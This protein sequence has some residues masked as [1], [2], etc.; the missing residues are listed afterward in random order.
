MD[1]ARCQRAKDGPSGN[2]RRKRGAQEASG[3]RAAFL[4]VPFL[5]PRKE[6]ELAFGCENPIKTICRDSDTLLNRSEFNSL[7]NIR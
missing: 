6:K 4:L 2:P 3:N 7:H 1:A 5:W